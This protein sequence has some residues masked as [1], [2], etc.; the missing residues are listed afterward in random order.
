[1]KTDERQSWIKDDW[2][3]QPNTGKTDCT[4][5]QTAD[6]LIFPAIDLA[7]YS[8]NEGNILIH[9]NGSWS[10]FALIFSLLLHLCKKLVYTW[11][12]TTYWTGTGTI[13]L[14]NL[15]TIP[16]FIFI[17]IMTLI[18]LHSTRFLFTEIL[19]LFTFT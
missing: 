6:L 10:N 18:L 7:T 19:Y 16:V 3:P 15:S 5:I 13:S 17:P 12:Y 4:G 8:L 14:G 9:I 11:T 2:T 1:M